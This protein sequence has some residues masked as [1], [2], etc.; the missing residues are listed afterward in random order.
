[1]KLLQS[2]KA[3]QYTSTKVLKFD[4]LTKPLL[5]ISNKAEI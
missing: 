5:E 1:M 3:W 4:F 2:F